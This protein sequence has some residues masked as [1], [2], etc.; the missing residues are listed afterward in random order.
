LRRYTNPVATVEKQMTHPYQ[1]LPSRAFW[2]SAVAEAD[3]LAFPDL[4]RPRLTLDHMTAVATAGSCFAQHIG[5]RLRQQGCRVLDA[6]TA[7]SMMPDTVAAAFGYRL[8][9]GRY[10]NIY[11]A[12]QMRQLLEDVASGHVDARHV[13]TKGDGFVDAFRPTVEPEGLATINEVLLHRAYHLERTSRMLLS[14][15]LFIFTLGLTEGWI[16][17]QT[18]RVYPL[19]PGVVAGRFDPAHHAFHNFR[20]AEVLED[21]VAI[22]ALL[23]RFNPAMQLLLTVSPVPLTATIEDDHVLTV[24]SASKAILRAAADECVKTT[25]GT[26]YFP[27]YE[28][29]THP[30]SGGPWFEPNLRSVSAAGVDRV[31]SIFLTAH[32]LETAGPSPD[33]ASEPDDDEAESGEDALVCDELLLQAFST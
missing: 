26:D 22:L 3:R 9:S 23:R 31:M 32:G 8:F 10:G 2:R 15:D 1:A 19:C 11:T 29:V 25:E 30:A 17:R 20:H 27:S 4:Y 5:K 7:P 13:W 33:V 12:R 6:E 21:L 14:T 18:G 16:D 24:T 28:I